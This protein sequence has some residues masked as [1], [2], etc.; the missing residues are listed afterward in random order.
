MFV[1]TFAVLRTKA[2]TPGISCLA[3]ALMASS[4]T[5]PWVERG[6]DVGFG[7]SLT[8]RRNKPLANGKGLRRPA[9]PPRRT[10]RV[11]PCA[12]KGVLV[13]A[14][15]RPNAATVFAPPSSPRLLQAPLWRLSPVGCCCG[16]LWVRKRV[17]QL[18]TRVCC[19][20][21]G[22]AMVLSE[23]CHPSLRGTWPRAMNIDA[24]PRRRRP[25]R[26]TER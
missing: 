15:T 18:G 10:G 23:P 26:L 9:G 4:R 12:G 11:N 22:P 3:M 5:Q 20:Y 13:V 16:R 14:A 7:G 2:P 25:L 6:R 1:G 8:S 21:P 24:L 19:C 17:R